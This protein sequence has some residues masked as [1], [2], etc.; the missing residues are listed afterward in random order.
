MSTSDVLKVLKIS[1]A[2]G[3]SILGSFKWYYDK[4]I[5]SLFSSDFE[6]VFG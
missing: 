4:K 1:R 5:T 6:S 2:V 3:V